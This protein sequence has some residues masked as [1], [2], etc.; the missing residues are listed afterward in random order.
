MPRGILCR[1]LNYSP[2]FV[3]TLIQQSLLQSL[4]CILKN[5]MSTLS[6]SSSRCSNSHCFC[7]T[8]QTRLLIWKGIWCLGVTCRELDGIETLTLQFTNKNN[9]PDKPCCSSSTGKEIFSADQYIT[10]NFACW[11]SS[12]ENKKRSWNSMA[13]RADNLHKLPQKK[14][15]STSYYQRLKKH[16]VTSSEFNSGNSMKVSFAESAPGLLVPE[17]YLQPQNN[18]L[19]T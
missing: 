6:K 19:D 8:L 18:P 7:F 1:N 5:L 13:R 17:F 10:F 12:F 2:S 16:M 3:T 11:L 15:C 4:I 9:P 14:G